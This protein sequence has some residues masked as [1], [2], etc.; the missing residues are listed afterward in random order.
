MKN[1]EAPPEERERLRVRDITEEMS[2]EELR[3]ASGGYIGETEKKTLAVVI[4]VSNS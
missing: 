1:S 2:E 4:A 3:K